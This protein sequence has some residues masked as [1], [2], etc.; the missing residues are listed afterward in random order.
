MSLIDG[1]L[2]HLYKKYAI[3]SAPAANSAVWE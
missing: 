2:Y 3:D 1:R